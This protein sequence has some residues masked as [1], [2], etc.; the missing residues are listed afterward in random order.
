MPETERIERLSWLAAEVREIIPE[1]T[2]VSSLVL[3]VP[4]W[5]GHLPGQHVSIRL[6]GEDGYQALRLYSIASPPETPQLILTVERIDDGEVS[7]YLV[8]QLRP[9]DRFELRGP[10]G[11]YFVWTVTTGGPLFL[12]GGGSGIAPLMAML[13]H[14]SANGSRV[15]TRL[16][17]SS[18]SEADIIYRDELAKLAANDD[19][20]RIIHTLTRER[21]PGWTGATRRIDRAMLAEVGFTPADKPQVFICGPNG[22]VESAAQHL[23]DVG[24]DPLT[25][26]TERFGPTT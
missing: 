11:G 17:Y 24:H 4:G 14:R 5:R 20:L 22:L 6:T 15:P 3:D 2:R 26:R 18:R 23:I 25:I 16:L 21:P 1:T 10:I 13:R 9:G 19:T 12:I 7:P 8:D